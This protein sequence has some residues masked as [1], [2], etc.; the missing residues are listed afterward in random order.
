MAR[1]IISGSPIRV[2]E[3]LYYL[4]LLHGTVVE[5][6]VDAEN[7]E[8][9]ELQRKLGDEVIIVPS[10][11][12]PGATEQKGGDDSV[13]EQYLE[14]YEV[15]DEKRFRKLIQAQREL[16]PFLQEMRREIARHFGPHKPVRL[17]LDESIDIY[18]DVLVYV[19]TP[20]I[21]ALEEFE[22][23]WLYEALDRYRLP[24]WVTLMPLGWASRSCDET[25]K[26]SASHTQ[27]ETRL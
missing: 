8:I 17:E 12:L 5:C 13:W 6:V 3:A 4:G 10:P 18:Q 2:I 21:D 23:A 20:S 11:T 15:D 1:W 22:R 24:F 16:I 25:R 7:D 14:Q 19:D 27:S 26:R 9:R